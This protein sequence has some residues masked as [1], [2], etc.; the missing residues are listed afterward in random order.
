[1][2]EGLFFYRPQIYFQTQGPFWFRLGQTL[3]PMQGKLK[4][5]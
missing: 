5:Q 3:D 1:M 4:S 2:A